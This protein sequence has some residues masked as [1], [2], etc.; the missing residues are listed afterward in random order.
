MC[1][2]IIE[3]A[4]RPMKSVRSR[5]RVRYPQFPVA[6]QD[7]DPSVVTAAEVEN[8]DDGAHGYSEDVQE[9][10]SEPEQYQTAH[11]HQYFMRSSNGKRNA[12]KM[13]QYLSPVSAYGT[14]NHDHRSSMRAWKEPLSKQRITRIELAKAHSRRSV[15]T[16]L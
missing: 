12:H 3:A 8:T 9:A 4:K 2:H 1:I 14:K 10:H 7:D 16:S 5:Q 6:A 13:I 11:V 15:H